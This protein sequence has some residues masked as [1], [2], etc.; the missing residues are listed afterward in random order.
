MPT[1]ARKPS[2]CLRMSCVCSVDALALRVVGDDASEIDGVA[3]DH[4]LAH[5]RPYFVTFD[6]HAT[7]LLKIQNHFLPIFGGRGNSATD[8]T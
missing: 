8:A 1:L 6:G 3:V 7:P 5:A 2:I 4:R